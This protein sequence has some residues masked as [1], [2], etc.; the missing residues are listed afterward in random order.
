MYLQEDI[1]EL[2]KRGLLA[3]TPSLLYVTEIFGCICQQRRTYRPIHTWR[4][5]T[6]VGYVGLLMDTMVSLDPGMHLGL[7]VKG[8]PP[9]PGILPNVRECD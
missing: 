8:C 3:L 5:F 6:S 7:K 9:L 2:Q 1:D 4:K